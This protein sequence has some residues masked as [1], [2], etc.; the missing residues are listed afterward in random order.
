MG[1]GKLLFNRYR[2]YVGND[3]KDSGD[4]YGYGY[5]WMSLMPLN[6]TFTND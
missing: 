3:K 4:G 5:I 2:V 1:N 6:C